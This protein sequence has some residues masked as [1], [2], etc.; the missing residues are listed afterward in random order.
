[1]R[2]DAAPRTSTLSIRVRAPPDAPPPEVARRPRPRAFPRPTPRPRCLGLSQPWSRTC[3]VDAAD[4]R[5]VRGAARTRAVR[6]VPW[7]GGIFAVTVTSRSSALFKHRLSPPCATPSRRP[8]LRPSR[9]ACL[10]A[11]IL[12]RAPRG[13]RRRSSAR[14]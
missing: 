11:C 6:G 14:H 10:L 3:A 8:P 7:Y 1:M 2:R 12:P 4:R 5:P 9:Q 13:L